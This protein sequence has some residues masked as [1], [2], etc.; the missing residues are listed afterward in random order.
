MRELREQ[1]AQGEQR[2]R[3]Q[4]APARWEP[5]EQA[6]QEERGQRE[7][8]DARP[9]R[10][11]PQPSPRAA[12]PP[13]PR[14]AAPAAG[15]YRRGHAPARPRAADPHL[16]SAMFQFE[17]GAQL[18]SN[19]LQRDDALPQALAALVHRGE[20]TCEC[21][22]LLLGVLRSRMR[23]LH[24]PLPAVALGAVATTG[25]HRDL[26]RL[27]PQLLL[28]VLPLLDPPQLELALGEL[29]R[30]ALP[31]ML[32][33]LL[34]P[35]QIGEVGLERAHRRLSRLRAAQQRGVAEPRAARA[36]LSKRVGLTLMRGMPALG[37]LFL[38]DH[39]TQS[40]GAIGRLPGLYFRWPPGRTPG[41]RRSRRPRPFRGSYSSSRSRHAMRDC[42]DHSSMNPGEA[43]CEK[44]PPDS[45][46]EARLASY[47]AWGDSRVTTRA[48]PL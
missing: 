43:A 3:E 16:R 13:Q 12:G 36:A 39:P 11:A 6:A 29:R 8:A 48:W 41:G 45:E 14:S 26:L 35:T 10:R 25:S 21:V 19:S 40:M 46:K 2:P 34:A 37:V 23:L 4:E 44:R 15:A 18:G 28:G 27:D 9:R 42:S 5:R 20:A 17:C 24:P 47:T 1:A 32:A 30:G 31:Q 33:L 22:S 38:G 7:S